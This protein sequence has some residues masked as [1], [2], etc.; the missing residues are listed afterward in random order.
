MVAACVVY[1]HVYIRHMV[2]LP[3]MQGMYL[4]TFM[5]PDL[6]AFTTYVYTEYGNLVPTS[7]MLHCLNG[8]RYGVCVRPSLCNQLK[9]TKI[10][11][12]CHFV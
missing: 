11:V 7:S 9:K 6:Q 12:G 5:C 1:T 8:F 2:C 10:K 3:Y 4:Q